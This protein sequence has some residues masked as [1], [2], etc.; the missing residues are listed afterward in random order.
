MNG[1]KP[2]RRDVAADP[3]GV[4]ARRAALKLLDAVIRR[5]QALEG[6]LH[7]ATQG[8]DLPQDRA[9]ASRRP[10]CRYHCGKAWAS[11]LDDLPRG[12]TQRL[13]RQGLA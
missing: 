5:G 7:N 13:Y 2:P 10:E 1:R 9:L 12:P 8:I 4:P 3:P 11:S 6:A